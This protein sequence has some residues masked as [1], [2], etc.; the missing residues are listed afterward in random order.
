MP[1]KYTLAEVEAIF[2]EKGCTLLT[3]DYINQ[4]QKLDYIA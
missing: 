2:K 3:K 4:L 1:E